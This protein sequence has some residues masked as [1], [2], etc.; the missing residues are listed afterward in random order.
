[1]DGTSAQFC[2]T[3]FTGV[4]CAVLA[5][6]SDFLV[7]LCFWVQ[8]TGRNY[9]PLMSLEYLGWL[10]FILKKLDRHRF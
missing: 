9:I 4:L 5:V 8:D 10:G 1:M 3:P 6:K 7:E 2:G